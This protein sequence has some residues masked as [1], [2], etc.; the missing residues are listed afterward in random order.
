MYDARKYI[1]RFLILKQSSKSRS[2]Y[3]II[4]ESRMNNVRFLNDA[5]IYITTILSIKLNLKSRRA[6]VFVLHE[7]KAS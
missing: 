6:N 2:A 1:I 7:G 3:I 4:S 5:R